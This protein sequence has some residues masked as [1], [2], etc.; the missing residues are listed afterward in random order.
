M[1]LGISSTVL[2]PALAVFA[3]D[4]TTISRGFGAA[5]RSKEA[6]P[7]ARGLRRSWLLATALLL[8]TGCG[9]IEQRGLYQAP[10]RTV[11]RYESYGSPGAVATAMPPLPETNQSAAGSFGEPSDQL[12]Q[13]PQSASYSPVAANQ[14]TYTP[15]TD[16]QQTYMDLAAPSAATSF[17]SQDIGRQVRALIAKR[18]ETHPDWAQ[19]LDRFYGTYGYQPIWYRGAWSKEAKIAQASL[20]KSWADGLPPRRYLPTEGIDLSRATTL[21]AVAR[22]ELALTQGMILFLPELREGLTARAQNGLQLLEAALA[23][24][25][26]A[27]ALERL[28]PQDKQFQGLRQAVLT[29]PMDDS[30][31]RLIALNMHRFRSAQEQVGGRRVRVNLPGYNLDVFDGA[32]HVMAMPVIVGQPD[33]AT[34]VLQDR[35]VNLKFSPD[36]SVPPVAAGEDLLPLLKHDAKALVEKMG[37]QAFRKGRAVDPLSIDWNRYS[38]SNLPYTFRQRPGPK[39]AMGGVRFSLTNPQDIYLHDTP[40]RDLF[41]EKVRMIS[42]GCVRVADAE[43]L[44]SWLLAQDQGWSRSQVKR[45]MAS[46]KT[47]IQPLKQPVAVDLVYYTALI[48]P[49]GELKLY[50]DIYGKDAELAAQLGL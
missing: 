32:R 44:A 38:A 35:I 3:A 34:P 15:S 18:A 31:K 26:F 25:N 40:E 22:T 12:S 1:G 14:T 45:A 20:T 37:L 30:A 10:G 33:R 13:V 6:R 11:T 23:S 43:K 7:T 4:R 50:P 9:L 24:G 5:I 29:V 8:V 42:S 46:G 36:W 48:D 16:P 27:T 49:S 28:R 41:G 19:T 2:D 39:N 21:N 17:S 47:H